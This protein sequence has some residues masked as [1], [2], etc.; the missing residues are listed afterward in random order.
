MEWPWGRAPKALRAMF[1]RA[2]VASGRNHASWV[3]R[4]FTVWRGV[5]LGSYLLWIRARRPRFRCR[6]RFHR[7]QGP[8]ARSPGRS[9][10]SRARPPERPPGASGPANPPRAGADPAAPRPFCMVLLGVYPG[11]QKKAVG[12]RRFFLSDG[13]LQ[14]LLVVPTGPSENDAVTSGKVMLEHFSYQ[15]LQSL[16]LLTPVAVSD[17]QRDHDKM[18]AAQCRG[19]R[20]YAVRSSCGPRRAGAPSQTFWDRWFCAAP[21]SCHVA[22]HSPV[23]P[24]SVPA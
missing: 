6:A 17:G 9:A 5:G 1:S 24:G 15:Q 22:A 19:A 20:R 23:P 14:A 12:A 3:S 18:Y 11:E 21:L 16:L 13:I 4:R 10:E 7:P 2:A 8:R